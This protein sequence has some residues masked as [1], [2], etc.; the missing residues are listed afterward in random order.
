MSAGFEIG[1][2]EKYYSE[3]APLPCFIFVIYQNL[4]RVCRQRERDACTLR[5]FAQ[6]LFY[7]DR[8]R[9]ISLCL[10]C[11]YVHWY[12]DLPIVINDLLNLF[13]ND[14]NI[15]IEENNFECKHD[16]LNIYIE[17]DYFESH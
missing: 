5:S 6:V 14:R 11:Q 13:C 4:K 17:S 16:F 2:F 10:P 1:N 9:T 8:N 15:S 3:N 12:I 7:L